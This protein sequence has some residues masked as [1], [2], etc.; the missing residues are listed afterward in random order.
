MKFQPPTPEEVRALR[1][2]HQLTQ[3]QLAELG[4]VTDR[5][6]QM[7]EAPTQTL[8]HR[9]PGEASWTLILHRLREKPAGTIRRIRK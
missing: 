2:K 6:V 8:S 9:Y 3:V 4:C 5:S 1:A 7:W